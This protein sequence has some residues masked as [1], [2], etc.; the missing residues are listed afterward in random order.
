MSVRLCFGILIA[1]FA[2]AVALIAAGPG[3]GAHAEPEIAVASPQ[4]S[5]AAAR[6]YEGVVTDT[7]CGAKHSTAIAQS[8]GDCA[9]MCAHSGEKF[10]LVDGERIYILDGQE[11]AIK[12]VAGERVGV[13]GTLNGNTISVV[14]VTP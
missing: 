4:S 2:F 8:A 3:V 1:G 13:F 11:A 14:S 5:S 6:T 12:R 7:H 9:R 10:A